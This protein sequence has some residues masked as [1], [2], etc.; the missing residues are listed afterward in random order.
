M[1]LALIN[2]S[3][4]TGGAAVVT[5]RLLDALTAE[6]HDA[7]LFTVEKLTDN[8]RVIPV[9]PAWKAKMPFYAERLDVALA[10]G[11]DRST[12]FRIDPASRG[13]DLAS[14]PEIREADAILLNWTNQ[15]MLSLGGL[16]RLARSGKPIVQ[17]MHDMWPFTGICHHAGECTHF[18]QHCGDCPLLERH[19]K[20]HDLSHRVW[21]KKM[22][23]YDRFPN[24]SFVAV[25]NWLA[26][27]ARESSLLR[28][29]RLSVI[30][31]AFP[32]SGPLGRTGVRPYIPPSHLSPRTSLTLLFGAARLDDPI[33]GLPVLLQALAILRDKRPELNLRLL[34]F[35]SMKN[36][37]AF[38]SC[39]VPVTH[40]GTIHG[41]ENVAKAYAQADITVSASQFETLPGT[42]VEAQAYG[43]LPV[44]FDR[45]GQSDIID[46]GVTGWLAPRPDDGP[47]AAEALADALSQAADVALDPVRLAETRRTMA[48][49]VKTRFSPHAVASAYLREVRGEK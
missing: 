44:A 43:C 48:D 30:P 38:D 7:R 35:G 27:K 22:E 33:K 20:P 19:S 12:L 13:L 9:A 23:I 2:K 40:L 49:S 8:P 26:D 32:I 25:S 45:G 28:N 46:H 47:L 36:P 16:E 31:N 6:G 15:G 34:T 18:T 5:R 24:I 14:V 41:E 4:S 42:L 39:P 3:D 1:K 21:K 37:D 10:N 11:F 17:T 29:R